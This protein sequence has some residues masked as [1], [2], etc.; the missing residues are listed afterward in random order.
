M[1]FLL[2]LFFVGIV[3]GIQNALAGGGSFLI[4]GGTSAVAANITSTVA[5][6]PGQIAT[7][8]GGRKLA[9]G[10]SGL[11][12]FTLCLISLLGGLCGAV[13]LLIT[14]GAVFAK[15]LPILVLAATGI[16]V[17]GNFFRKMPAPGQAPPAMPHW[18][19]ILMQFAIAI[20]GGYFGG[21]IGILMLAAFTMAGQEVKI[22]AATKNVLNAVLNTTAVAIFLFSPHL[23]RE[24]AV[25]V[26]AGSLI[27]GQIGTRLLAKIPDQPLR[28]GI[29]VVGVILSLALWL[30]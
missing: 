2:A 4:W 30:K 11:G 5:L 7:G 23:Q 3:A 21:G 6:W 9:S 18:A 1:I 22:A 15:L 10:M 24:A 16:F 20:Y 19:A 26:G 29:I 13:L 17:W 28:I 12:L 14:P 25:F 27:G 8:Y